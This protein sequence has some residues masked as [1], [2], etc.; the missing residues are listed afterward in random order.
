MHQTIP[1]QL[2]NSV[3][4]LDVTQPVGSTSTMTFTNVDPTNQPATVVNDLTN[5][6]NEY[7]WHCHILGHEEND[8]MRA[9]SFVVPPVAPTIGTATLGGTNTRPTITLRWTN[10]ALNQTALTVQRAAGTGA[11]ANVA[12]LAPN[13]TTWTDSTATGLARRTTYTYRVV[14]NNVVGYTRAYTAPAVGYPH[15]QADSPPSAASNA[16]TTN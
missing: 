5:F 11:W 14:A 10:N 16:V 1:W 9:T 2:P 12:T 7:T 3:R 6:G 13:A 15:V 4:P 8:M